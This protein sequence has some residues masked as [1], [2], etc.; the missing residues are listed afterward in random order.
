MSEAIEPP[1]SKEP[2]P[3]YPRRSSAATATLVLAI[4][5]MAAVVLGAFPMFSTPVLLYLGPIAGL[6]ALAA[7]I[8]FTGSDLVF[9]FT[10]NP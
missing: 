3:E 2:P 10:H 6:L 8:W 1:P 9:C 5:A 7:L 4:C